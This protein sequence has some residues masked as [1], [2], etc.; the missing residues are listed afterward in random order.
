MEDCKENERA[1]SY[2]SMQTTST[3]LAQQDPETKIVNNFQ[4]Y[5]KSKLNQDLF[6]EN[7]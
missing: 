5:C 6:A 7:F 4:S 2:G 1:S 3:M